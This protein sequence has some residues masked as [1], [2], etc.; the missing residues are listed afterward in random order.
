MS[1]SARLEYLPQA[2]LLRLLAVVALALAPHLPRVPTWEAAVV[3]VMLAWRAAASLRTWP[4]PPDRLKLLMT[5]C[6]VVAVAA[7]HGA[8]PS[9]EAGLALL[10]LMLAFKLTELRQRRDVMVT[11]FLLYFVLLTQFLHSQEIWTVAY[12]L[13]CTVAVTAVLIEVSHP[14]TMLAPTRALR[15]AAGHVTLALPVMVVLFVLFPR[16]P[17]PLWGL[18]ADGGAAART[19]LSDRMSPGDI[20]SLIAS[21]EVAFRVEFDGALPPQRALYWRGPVFWAF[22]GRTWSPGFGGSLPGEVRIAPLGPALRY[23]MMLEPTSE[24]WLTALEMVDP[25][26]LPEGASLS[27]D[28]LLTSSTRSGERRLVALASWPEY[29]LEPELTPLRHRLATRLPA[30]RNPR[31]VALARQWRAQ[32]LDD[33][34]IMRQALA[35][36]R[37][38]PFVYTMRPPLLGADPV[39]EFLFETRRGFCEHYASAFAVLMRAAGIPARIVTGYQGGEYSSLGGYLLVRQSD[40]HAWVEVHLPGQG[41]QRVDPTAAVAPTRVERGL[42]A[43]LEGAADRPGWLASRTA[44]RYWLEARWDLVNA[45]WNRW[46]LAYGPQLQQELMRALGLVTTGRMILALTAA[47]TLLAAAYGLVLL[48]AVRPP[49]EHDPV[50]R[51]WRDVERLLARAGIVRAANEGPRDF[52]LRACGALPAVAD[53]LQAALAHYLAARYYGEHGAGHAE[54]LANARRQLREALRR[55]R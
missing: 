35:L 22:D 10:V 46:V 48:R 55:T 26:A 44:L 3:L 24:R 37:E 6:A 32:G 31:A 19:G 45:W 52:A 30:G 5:L 39:D 54:A 21:D 13:G 11:V 43:A 38:Q 7:S 53:E 1:A 4:M 25:A 41:W 40:A 47:L 23:R 49:A 28:H 8:R 34:A 14:G 51:Q 15:M 42:A 29:R 12:L 9:Q 20:A 50:Q 18:P 27:A 17:G 33:A 16:I 36:F 2:T